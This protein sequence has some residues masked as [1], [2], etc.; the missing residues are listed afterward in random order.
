MQIEKTTQSEIPLD[1]FFKQDQVLESNMP[2]GKATKGQLTEDLQVV[3]MSVTEM[4]YLMH[5]IAT[6]VFDAK[7]EKLK[8]EIEDECE[9]QAL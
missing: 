1:N 4:K 5:T 2:R 9:Y 7:K 6:E 8:T 3:S